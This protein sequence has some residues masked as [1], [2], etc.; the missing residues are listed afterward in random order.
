MLAV[1]LH[2]R[3]DAERKMWLQAKMRAARDV[4]YARIRIDE[5]ALK[6]QKLDALPELLEA[7]REAKKANPALASQATTR[8]S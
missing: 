1:P 7:I 5:H 2:Y 4:V 8:A 3:P 6:R